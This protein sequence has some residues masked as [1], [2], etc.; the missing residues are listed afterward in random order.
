MHKVLK[1]YSK[2]AERRHEVS[3]SGQHHELDAHNGQV[4][5]AGGGGGP[6]GAWRGGRQESSAYEMHEHYERKVQRVKK[7]RKE[8][9][10]NKRNVS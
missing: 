1:S 5:P 8:R 10:G 9:D 7:T 4:V 6:V 2:K 3:H